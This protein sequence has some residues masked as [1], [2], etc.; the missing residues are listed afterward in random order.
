MMY[1]QTL[2]THW[3]ATF[4]MRVKVCAPAQQRPLWTAYLPLGPRAKE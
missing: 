2:T 1:A 3:P 4:A